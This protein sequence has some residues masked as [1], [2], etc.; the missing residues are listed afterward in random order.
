M[1][2]LLALLLTLTL[3]IPFT[4]CGETPD[5][6]PQP[7]TTRVGYFPG[8][9]GIG[10]AKMIADAPEG[11]TFTKYND[12]TFITTA[13][14]AGEIDI[15]AFPTNGVPN[16]Y[17]NAMGGN[18]LM[19]AI[20]TLG[21]LHICT[22]GVEIN[23]IEDLAGKTVY[24]PADAPKLV[25]EYILKQKGVDNVELLPSTLDALPAA[26]ASGETDLGESVQIAVLPEPKVSAAAA[27]ATKAGSTTFKVAL[28]LTEEW[29]AVS[30]Q[31][32]VQGCVVVNRDFA[33]DNPEAVAD[34]LKKYEASI[35]FIKDPANLEQAA[36]MVVDAG[37]L[38]A[39]PVAKQAI[40]RSN[41]T[42]MSGTA[43]KAAATSFIT[44]LGIP[45]PD[46][47]MFYLPDND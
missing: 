21:V 9:T 20:N 47:E 4:A 18:V 46:G 3:L 2:K 43:M 38:P 5:P 31:P 19:L 17:R 25:L 34:F 36:Q 29:E 16:L 40:P 24:Y 30:D 35:N 15:A 13:L 23:A 26:I 11:Y 12:Q 6:A 7:V 1:K 32:L 28:D 14:Q 22:N 37:I 45:M 39:V 10:M 42:F 27:Q 41:I 8:T 33:H 44:A